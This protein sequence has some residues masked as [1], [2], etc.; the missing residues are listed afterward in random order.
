MEICCCSCWC[1]SIAAII[2]HD[3]KFPFHFTI[4]QLVGFT[5]VSSTNSRNS[6]VVSLYFVGNLVSYWIASFTSS[7]VPT[8]TVVAYTFLSESTALDFPVVTNVQPINCI[9]LS[10]LGTFNLLSL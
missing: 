4:I 9:L 7:M 5:A 1:H 6:G 3:V 8:S 10:E 2:Q